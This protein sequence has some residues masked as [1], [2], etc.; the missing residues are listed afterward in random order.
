MCLLI[1]TRTISSSTRRFVHDAAVVYF[2]APVAS[3]VVVVGVAAAF[4][5]VAVA[6]AVAVVCGCCFAL[7]PWA[8]TIMAAAHNENPDY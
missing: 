4:V 2:V 3:A 6:A 5:G 8:M 7:V 1:K